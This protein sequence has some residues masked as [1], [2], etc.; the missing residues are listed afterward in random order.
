MLTNP[1]LDQLKHLG[2]NG[3]AAAFED[4][5][6][7]QQAS[8][9]SHAEWL[10]LL[11]DR[12]ASLRATRRL[13][14]RLRAARLR[15]S[16]ACVEDLDFKT[17]RGLDRSAVMA[18]AKG[19]WLEQRENLILTGATGTGKS[20]LSCALGHQA[21]RLDYS[22]LYCR[23]PRLFEDLAL[24]RQDGRYP[25]L[26]DRLAKVQL[27]ILD[28]WGTHRLSAQ[29]RHD[30]LELTEERYQRRST[31]ITAQ[32]PVSEW[33]IVIDEPTIADAIL[34]RIIHNAHRIT[35]TGES[36]RKTMKPPALTQADKTAKQS[37][38]N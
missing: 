20:W 26:I 2:L 35:L 27:L 4:I 32:V 5:G 23:V 7:D 12:E 18:L 15:F 10:A 31:V 13:T 17:P 11:L 36:M 28:D 25:R 34:D 21:A 22:V 33:H 8:E 38:R 19:T 37:I 16:N 9:L 30:I 1:T 6:Q 29:Q 14:N 3:M 24:A